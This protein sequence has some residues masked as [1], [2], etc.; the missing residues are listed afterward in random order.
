MST[1][2]IEKRKCLGCGEEITDATA[3]CNGE[4]CSY[5]CL[6]DSTDG[7]DWEPEPAA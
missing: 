3:V 7:C 4:W 6:A 5:A 2:I 1:E